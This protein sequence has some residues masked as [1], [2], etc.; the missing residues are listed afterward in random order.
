MNVNEAHAARRTANE[1]LRR[2][3]LILR[4]ED[5]YRYRDSVSDSVYSAI[6]DLVQEIGERRKTH[7]CAGKHSSP[8]PGT[9]Y[10]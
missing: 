4:Q 10:S 6:E 8:I 1:I 9:P 7:C 3:E 2:L 5:N